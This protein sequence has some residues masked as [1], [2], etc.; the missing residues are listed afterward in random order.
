MN[1]NKDIKNEMNIPTPPPV[2]PK[3]GKKKILVPII[4]VAIVAV[5]AVAIPVTLKAIIQNQ[6]IQ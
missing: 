1:E 5:L 6:K 2:V 3:K 4:I